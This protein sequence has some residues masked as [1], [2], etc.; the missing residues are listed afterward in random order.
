[1]RYALIG[2]FFLTVAP[3]GA[4]TA[5]DVFNDATLHEVRLTVDPNDWRTLREEYLTDTFYKATFQWGD[6]KLENVGIR[7]R[8][9]GSRNA[10]KP[11]LKVDFNEYVSQDFVGL[12]SVVLDNLV[13]DAAGMSERLSLALFRRAGVPA[14]RLAH[15]RLYVN[16][17]YVGLYTMVEPVDKTFLRRVYGEDKGDL[18]DYE[19][20]YTYG[21]EYFGDDGGAYFPVPFEPKTNEKSYDG[22][23]FIAMLRVINETPDEEFAGAIAPYVDARDYVRY[24]AAEAYVGDIDGQLGDWGINNF[25]LYRRPGGTQFTFIAW[26]KDVT[27]RDANRSIW[28]NVEHNQLARRILAVPE[29]RE[30]YLAALEEFVA[31]AEGPGGW[32][33]QELDRAHEQINVAALEDTLSPYP[34]SEFYLNVSLVRGYLANRPGAIAAQIEEARLGAVPVSE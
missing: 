26:D 20:A 28:A 17:N 11:G 9:L 15:A 22:A 1:M 7:S 21:F 10:D 30:A 33:E 4:A 16:D 14:P 27:F 3:G 8:G 12:K 25:Y 23:S 31:L 24:L 6:L 2:L 18:Y 5:D 19:W 13:Q 34:Y 29:Y 32:L